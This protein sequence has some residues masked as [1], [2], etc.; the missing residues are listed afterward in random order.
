[1]FDNFYGLAGNPFALAPDPAFYFCSATHRKALSYLGYGLAQ[2]GG[3]VVLTGE[4]GTGKSILAA[5]LGSTAEAER[6][7]VGQI[8]GN[9]LDGAEIDRV[10]AQAFGLDIDGHEDEASSRSAIETFLQGEARAGRRCL[11]MLDDAQS[12]EIPVLEG[13]CAL[14]NA[15]AGNRPLVQIA[16]LGRPELGAELQEKHELEPLR[17]RVIAAPRLEPMERG[18]IEPYIVYRLG[19]AG[20]GGKPSFDQRVFSELHEA[21][22][23]VPRR[24]NRIVH[25]LLL[26]GAVEQRARID[27]LMLR[28]V[29]EEMAGDGTFPRAAPVVPPA[30]TAPAS[31]EPGI[32]RGAIE[33]LLTERDAQIAE[34]QQAIVEMANRTDDT[35]TGALMPEIVALQEKAAEL[36]ASSFEQERSIRYALTMLI[37]W[38][39]SDSDESRAA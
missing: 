13:L 35:R 25:R 8:A 22:G 9:E 38:I 24:I 28:A 36:E 7:S 29:L 17:Q 15:K 6:L 23:G 33:A 27:S 30:A 31:R 19:K 14:S 20:Y 3:F 12:L 1:M 26:L 39:E 16:L 5:H 37:E 34:L 4:E 10:V 11:L 2:G 32:E 21:T 18:E